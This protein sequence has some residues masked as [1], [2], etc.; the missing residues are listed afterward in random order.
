VATVCI[1]SASVGG[2]YWVV[3]GAVGEGGGRGWV[4][5]DAGGEGGGAYLGIGTTEIGGRGGGAGGAIAAVD[6]AYREAAGF[7]G[8]AA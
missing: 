6:E 5:K 8:L 3:I 7:P 2:A 4:V 1:L